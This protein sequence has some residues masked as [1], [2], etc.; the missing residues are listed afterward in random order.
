MVAITGLIPGV[1]VVPGVVSYVSAA[2]VAVG[3]MLGAYGGVM[4]ARAWGWRR[5]WPSALAAALAVA[6]VLAGVSSAL[7]G[8]S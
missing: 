2:F 5:Q 3:G 8:G 1:G 7:P 6:V 4:Q